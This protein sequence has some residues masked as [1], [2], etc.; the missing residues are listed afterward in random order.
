MARKEEGDVDDLLAG[1]AGDE[2]ETAGKGK[3]KGK[4]KGDK[5]GKGGKVEKPAAKAKTTTKPAKAAVEK[6]G[7][8][9]KTTA[10][11]NG[12]AAKPAAKKATGKG[13]GTPRGPR[14]DSLVPTIQ[15]LLGKVRKATPYEEIAEKA[16]AS[17]RTVRRTARKMRDAGSIQLKRNGQK[18][19]IS[20]A[21]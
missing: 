12:K 3:G 10:K 21:I 5:K 8:A 17:I 18:V 9:A 15:N 4:G 14:P 1:P 7:K 19:Y 13:T 16:G 20:P 6:G 11:G 2:G